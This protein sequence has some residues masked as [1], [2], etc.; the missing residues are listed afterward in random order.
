LAPA[1]E[2]KVL[3]HV[4]LVV[5]RLIAEID[6]RL[7]E[8]TYPCDKAWVFALEVINVIVNLLINQLRHLLFEVGWELF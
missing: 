5:D 7:E 3:Q 1:K 2:I 6:A 8:R 4:L